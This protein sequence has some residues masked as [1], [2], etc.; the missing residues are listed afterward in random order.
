M[1]VVDASV[2]AP[3]LIDSDPDGSEL[4]SL[5]SGHE[6]AAPQLLDLEVMSIYRRH[7]RSG[8]VSKAEADSA[9]RPDGHTFRWMSRGRQP[10]ASGVRARF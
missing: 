6:L 4:R 1:I 10:A 2:L 5:L 9:V 7:C 8:K 3:A